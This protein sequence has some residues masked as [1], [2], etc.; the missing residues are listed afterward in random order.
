MKEQ[1]CNNPKVDI[2]LY[3]AIASFLAALTLLIIGGHIYHP[4]HV[5]EKYYKENI[6][7]VLATGYQNLTCE[8]RQRKYTCFATTWQVQLEKELL[9]N[10]ATIQ[11]GKKH[12]TV[13]ATL[14]ATAKYQVEIYLSYFFY[15]S[16][17]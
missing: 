16:L 1:S 8:Q 15:P 14:A 3:F 17:V 4:E 5:K 13:N 2:P 9:M 12:P 6:C 10:K 11:D 7:S